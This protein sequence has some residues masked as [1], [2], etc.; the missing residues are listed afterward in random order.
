MISKNILEQVKKPLPNKRQSILYS[1]RRRKSLS[2]V[3]QN[4]SMLE[5]NEQNSKLIEMIDTLDY[6][7]KQIRA[8]SEL[9]PKSKNLIYLLKLEQEAIKQKYLSQ[10]DGKSP[11]VRI[12]NRMFLQQ[13]KP[14]G[15]E[16]N[17]TLAQLI[18]KHEVLQEKVEKCMASIQ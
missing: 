5:R 8:D 7:L 14:K 3:K 16:P 15:F 6:S 10:F 13:T 1:E 17:M 9:D 18:N 4:L 11:S 12:G 2:L